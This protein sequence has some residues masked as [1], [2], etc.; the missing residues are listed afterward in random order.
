MLRVLP[1]TIYKIND[2][3]YLKVTDL[4][5][6]FKIKEFVKT[7][8]FENGRSYIVKNG[9]TP[10]IVSYKEYGTSRFESFI[11]I[12]NDIVS[13]YDEWPRSEQ[14]FREFIE[15][16]YGSLNYAKSNVANYY[17]D[18]GLKVTRD[19]WFSLVQNDKYTETFYEYEERL[20][21][22]KSKIKLVDYNLMINFEVE[23]R[24]YVSKLVTEEISK[25]R[26]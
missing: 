5:F 21:D 7:F 12:L 18:D 19:T 20:N 25:A 14:S 8:S 2:F 13:V 26:R 23:L 22:E 15:K 1:K 4:T 17:R 10:S 11:L 16:K 24:R 6:Y 9:D 3:D